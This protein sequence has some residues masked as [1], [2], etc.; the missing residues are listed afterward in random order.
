MVLVH[1]KEQDLL[2]E[3]TEKGK[4]IHIESWP[5]E[6]KV[7]TS[8][9]DQTKWDKLIEIITKIRQAKSEA[10]KSMKAEILL[11][12]SKED[13]KIL[14]PLLADLKAVTTSKEIKEGSFKVEFI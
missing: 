2:Q 3:K 7:K 8:K 12:L 1:L 6:F 11:T 9:E 10:K 5:T 4:S 13:H 14:L